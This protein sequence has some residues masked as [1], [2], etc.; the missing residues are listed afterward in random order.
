MKI[1]PAID[2]KNGECVRLTQGDF[3]TAKIYESDPLKQAALFKDAG[4]EWLHIVDLDG[5]KAGKMQQFGLIAKL[6][7]N[8]PLK[9]QTGGGI[10]DAG[11]IEKLLEAGIQRV[12]IGSLATKDSVLVKEWLVRFGAERIALA[13]DIKLTEA[14][15][16]EIMTHGWQTGSQQLLWDILDL[17]K[18]SGLMNILC[19]DVGRDGMLVGANNLL[20]ERIQRRAPHLAVLAS[21]GVGSIDDL[22]GLAKQKIAGAIVGKAIYEGQVDLADAIAQVKNAG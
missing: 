9:I 3:A 2:L 1:Y 7:K 6:A 14:N 15:E 20:Y 10:R 16:P 17:Y 22:L 18:N 8:S 4:A 13:F 11:T 12:V 5:A 19:T 21:G